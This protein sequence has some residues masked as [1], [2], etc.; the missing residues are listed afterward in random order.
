MEKLKLHYDVD[1][2][3]FTSAGEASTDV[4]RVL[5]RLGFDSD[6]MRRVAICMYE[7]EINLVIHGG[8]GVAD[9]EV[10]ENEVVI[11]LTDHGPGIPDVEQAM[12]EGWS[13]ASQTVRELGFGAGMGLPNMKRYSDEIAIESTIGE[14]TTVTMKIRPA[15]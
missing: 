8:G 9:V 15:G 4:K 14:G 5:R 3:D 12:Q 1:G 11:V 2:E 13:T 7:G 10:D 6:T